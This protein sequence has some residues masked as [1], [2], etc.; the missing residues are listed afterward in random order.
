MTV[1]FNKRERFITANI[2]KEYHNLYD[3]SLA[4]FELKDK[5]LGVL[6][7]NILDKIDFS[8]DSN[9]VQLLIS[10]MNEVERLLATPPRVHQNLKTK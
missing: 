1:R 10:R 7:H 4:V 3:K 5:Q 6:V 8:N 2:G 9:E